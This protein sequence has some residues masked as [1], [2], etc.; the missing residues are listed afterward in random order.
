MLELSNNVSQPHKHKIFDRAREAI[1]IDMEQNVFGK[2]KTKYIV[3]SKIRQDINAFY[4]GRPLSQYGL[5]FET[6]QNEFI[7]YLKKDFPGCSIEYD[8]GFNGNIIIDWS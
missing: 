7:E 8:F 2:G 1:W 4:Y 5:R 3:G 6:F